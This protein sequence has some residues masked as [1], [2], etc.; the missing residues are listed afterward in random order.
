RV[1]AR[2]CAQA[3]F[4]AAGDT[5]LGGIFRDVIG[6]L[7][8]PLVITDERGNPRA[9]RLVGVD[10][11]LV[12]DASLDSLG[13]PTPPSPVIL[14][15]IERV[16]SRMRELD[17]HNRPIPIYQPTTPFNLADLHY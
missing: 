9:W 16:R 1:L 15:R 10:E 4:P 8:F 12:P 7:E 14:A 6:S 2:F 3:S 13:T 17:R 5:L 11:A